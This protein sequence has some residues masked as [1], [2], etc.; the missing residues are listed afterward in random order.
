MKDKFKKNVFFGC[1]RLIH[2][3]KIIFKNWLV[4]LGKWQVF[5][6]KWGFEINMQLLVLFAK[7][8]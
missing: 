1:I 8:Q 7:M 4:L 6:L 3:S 5:K 2:H